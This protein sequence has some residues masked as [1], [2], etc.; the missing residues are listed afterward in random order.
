M[1]PN[2]KQS[3]VEDCQKNNRADADSRDPYGYFDKSMKGFFLFGNIHRA[4]F[5]FSHLNLPLVSCF[6]AGYRALT[7]K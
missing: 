6:L 1:F 4:V 5:V 7:A 3:A 2:W